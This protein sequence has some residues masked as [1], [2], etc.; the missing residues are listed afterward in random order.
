MKKRKQKCILASTSYPNSNCPLEY[1]HIQWFET[2][3]SYLWWVGMSL[4]LQ[5]KPKM[6]LQWEL[7]KLEGIMWLYPSRSCLKIFSGFFFL[8]QD[9]QYAPNTSVVALNTVILIQESALYHKDRF[10]WNSSKPETV[11]HMT[12][13]WETRSTPAS[14][15][16]MQVDFQA[17]EAAGYL[18]A[19]YLIPM[20]SMTRLGLDGGGGFLLYFCG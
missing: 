9:V 11:S 17:L 20:F 4:N 2:Q 5:P 7:D 10:Q 12:A 1:S 16:K 13:F 3:M 14:S 6:S 18:F 19:P 15:P 8:L